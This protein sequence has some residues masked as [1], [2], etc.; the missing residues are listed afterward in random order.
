MLGGGDSET[1]EVALSTG[2]DGGML[3]N[4]EAARN[5]LR[6]LLDKLDLAE[7]VDADDSDIKDAFRL[8]ERFPPFD[9]YL[10][11]VLL[12][13]GTEELKSQG[14]AGSMAASDDRSQDDPY[15][16]NKY[17][18]DHGL[19]RYM[20]NRRANPNYV[21]VRSNYT[22][23]TF[24]HQVFP[25]WDTIRKS[26]LGLMVAPQGTDVLQSRGLEG[27]DEPLGDFETWVQREFPWA[28]RDTKAVDEK[29]YQDALSNG[30]EAAQHM[31]E[32]LEG[33]AS[34]AGRGTK[35][36][37]EIQTRAEKEK[38]RLATDHLPGG[39][40]GTSADDGKRPR[41]EAGRTDIHSLAANQGMEN[42]LRSR[43]RNSG[44]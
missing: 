21:D 36:A 40:G 41:T 33:M 24:W 26:R 3:T 7:A 37:R 18:K 1:T 35:T 28:D 11:T 6:A 10:T 17:P 16:R 30:D 13:T 38:R 14:Y 12:G 23:G 39:V 8:K 9:K 34:V 32:Y 4:A 20:R 27:K 43:T 5:E 44:K 22:N 42:E 25:K 31:K 15:L 29:A 19:A 2:T